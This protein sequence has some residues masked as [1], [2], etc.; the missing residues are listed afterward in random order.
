[1]AERETPEQAKARSADHAINWDRPA[2]P[3]KVVEL[4]DYLKTVVQ[5]VK[6]ATNPDL[7]KDPA[8]TEQALKDN[9]EI[10]DAVMAGEV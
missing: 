8:K 1:M 10:L 9:K 7:L 4:D 2:D 6:A 3:Q 5:A